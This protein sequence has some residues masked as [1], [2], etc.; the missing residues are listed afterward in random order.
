MPVSSAAFSVDAP[1]DVSARKRDRCEAIDAQHLGDVWPFVPWTDAHFE[2][3]TRLHGIDPA[4]SED[5]PM[6]EG[7]TGPIGEFDEAEAFLGIEPL[8]DAA[9]RW[10]RG[11]LK[12]GLAEPGAIAESTGLWMVGIGVEFATPRVTKILLSH[13]SSWR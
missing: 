3:F 7:V 12:S 2:G 1:F 11:W 8:D 9:D 6:K 5:S 13:F 10:T 4:L